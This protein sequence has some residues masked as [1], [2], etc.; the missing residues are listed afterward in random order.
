LD[1]EHSDEPITHFFFPKDWNQKGD[2]Q[3]SIVAEAATET[4][5]PVVERIREGL[6]FWEFATLRNLLETTD[7]IL[8]YR[9]VAP[10][11]VKT[12]LS[13]EGAHLYRGRWNSPGRPIVYLATSR[14]LAALE[15]LVRLTRTGSRRLPRFSRSGNPIQHSLFL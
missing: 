5:T 8:T 11:W 14:A 9:L 2:A 7:S 13:G 12:A 3:G 15:L 4:Q 1:I 6:S 10:K